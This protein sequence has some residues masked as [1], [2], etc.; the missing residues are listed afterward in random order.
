MDLASI[1]LTE[2]VK[3]GGCAAKLPAGE[4]R[5]VLG[6]LAMPKLPELAVGTETTPSAQCT[7]IVVGIKQ[8]YDT[9]RGVMTAMGPGV[10]SGLAWG[11]NLARQS[12][13][14]IV[15]AQSEIGRAH[16]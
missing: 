9:V 13:V 3:K 1:R 8:Y 6:S 12:R 10:P 15:P 14:Y 5:K 2:T 16:V 11:T 7:G 4:L